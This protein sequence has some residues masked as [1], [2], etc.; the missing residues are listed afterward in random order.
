MSTPTRPRSASESPR[1]SLRGPAEALAARVA[2]V[3]GVDADDTTRRACAKILKTPISDIIDDW[4]STSLSLFDPGST[5]IVTVDV[6]EDTATIKAATDCDPV[7]AA[8]THSALVGTA[9]YDGSLASMFV[10]AND[11]DAGDDVKGLG[12]TSEPFGATAFTD[13]PVVGGLVA[14]TLLAMASHSGDFLDVVT[15]VAELPLVEVLKEA[16]PNTAPAP[17]RATTKTSR[18]PINPIDPSGW[19]AVAAL[20]WEFIHENDDYS[21]DDYDFCESTAWAKAPVNAWRANAL[22]AAL[23]PHFG[24]AV[25][26]ITASSLESHS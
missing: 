22:R 2:K 25:D 20:A 17:A 19:G 11:G 1:K 16:V 13:N 7:E 4:R 6:E 3:L 9:D 15:E 12:S 26:A 24:D 8:A 21:D 18:I 14:Q 23:R 5:N 10:E